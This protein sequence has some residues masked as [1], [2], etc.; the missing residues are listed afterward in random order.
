MP[1]VKAFS[2]INIIILFLFANQI[3][4][5]DEIYFKNGRRINAKIMHIDS[6]K[7]NY[8]LYEHLNGPIHVENTSELTLIFFEDGSYKT[9]FEKQTEI[10]RKYSQ[11]ILKDSS[12]TSEE[13]LKY[14]NAFYF[15]I[16]EVSNLGW[17]IGYRREQILKNICLHV[18]TGSTFGEPKSYNLHYHPIGG[19]GVTNIYASKKL[20]ENGIGIYYEWGN[21]HR[22]RFANGIGYKWALFDGYYSS[23]VVIV[24]TEKI[25]KVEH[26]KIYYIYTPQQCRFYE[27]YFTINNYCIIKSSPRLNMLININT[28]FISH[29]TF[30]KNNPSQYT[31]DKSRVPANLYSFYLQLGV[32][33]G[34]KF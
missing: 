11:D 20:I 30:I 6:L 15:N 17:S 23:Y 28:G 16:L 22:I 29:T 33:V 26:K 8:Y 1:G 34:V 14:K 31:I 25:K 19:K 24:K 21:H 2:V 7:I 4:S 18:S 32:L 12:Y 27:H 5:Q 13:I 3:I 10:P 9:F